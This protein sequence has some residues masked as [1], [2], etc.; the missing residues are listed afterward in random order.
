MLPSVDIEKGIKILHI[1]RIEINPMGNVKMTEQF[2]DIEETF[3]DRTNEAKCL[4]NRFLR[5]IN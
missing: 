4:Q 3:I 2:F 1:D 5:L